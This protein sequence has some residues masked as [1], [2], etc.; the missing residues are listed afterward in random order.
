MIVS[1]VGLSSGAAPEFLDLSD[2]L[3]RLVPR[4]MKG[5]AGSLVSIIDM[6]GAAA[7]R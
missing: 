7:E 1:D 3:T 6:I 2:R 5:E 4:I